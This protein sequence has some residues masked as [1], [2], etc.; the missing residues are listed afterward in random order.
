MNAFERLVEDFLALHWSYHPVDAGFAGIADSMS[1][2]PSADPT[3]ATREAAELV[4]LGQRLETI[5]IPDNAGARLDARYIRAQVA[6]SQ[7]LATARPPHLNP[8]W[9][10]GEAAFGLICH[11]LPR[12]LPLDPAGFMARLKALPDFLDQGRRNLAGEPT[13]KDWCQRARNEAQALIR[14]LTT[15]LPRHPIVAHVEGPAIDRAVAACQAFADAISDLPDRSPQAGTDLLSFL[16]REIH[17]LDETPETLDRRAASAFEHTLA[18]LE[19]VATRLDPSKAWTE[20]LAVLAQITP[21]DPAQVLDTYRHWHLRALT[22]ADKLVTPAT[23]YGLDFRLLP[24]WAVDCAADLYFLFYRSPSLH[25][26]GTG[27]IYWVGRPGDDQ[28]AYLRGQNI[29]AIKQIH[30]VHHGSIGHHTQNA[31]ARRAP[32]RIAQVAG[33]D[34]ASGIMFPGAG[35][36]VEGWPC[37][38]EDLMDEVPDFYTPLERLQLL[39]FELR[40]IATCLADTRLHNGTW[41]LEDMRRFYRDDV[42]FAPARIWSESTRN[43]IYPATRLMYWTGMEQIRSLRRDSTLDTRRFHDTL[44]SYGSAPV[45][46][47]GEEMRRAKP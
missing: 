10:T 37:Y 13:P 34:C 2:L 47:I 35:S 31:R 12:D 33:T 27:S 4:A 41:N 17:G 45:A 38:A 32:S 5:D 26:A 42:Y 9:Y 39:H 18:L 1:D 23:D 28:S 30:A 46:W 20:H 16:I 15:G 8:S 36:L 25:A 3:A 11:L 21:S 6:L 40:N 29:A 22:G 19:E 7:K 43:S 14:L 44:L 24:E